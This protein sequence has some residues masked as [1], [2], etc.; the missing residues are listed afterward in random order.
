ME[1]SYCLEEIIFGDSDPFASIDKI[2]EQLNELGR[3]GW[4]AVA[5]FPS[6]QPDTR[7]HAFVLFK[8]AKSK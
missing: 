5:A 2:Q 3:A 6:P 4:E 1:W 7:G 8:Y